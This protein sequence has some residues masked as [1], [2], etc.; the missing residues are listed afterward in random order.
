MEKCSFRY[1]Y[2]EFFS[3]FKSS[4]TQIQNNVL[5]ICY[6]I[7]NSVCSKLKSSITLYLCPVVKQ[8]SWK[9]FSFQN[10]DLKVSSVVLPVYKRAVRNCS[11]SH[12]L[13]GGYIRALERYHQE[14]QMVQGIVLK[15]VPLS[16]N[17]KINSLNF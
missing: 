5:S 9:I 1:Y 14:H 6:Y 13:W 4:T 7:Y 12:N 10:K 15:R 11:W 8:L 16:K 17:V 3:S 2:F